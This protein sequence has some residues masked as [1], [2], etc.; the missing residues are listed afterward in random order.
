MA[1]K[2]KTAEQ[3]AIEL[4]HLKMVHAGNLRDKYPHM[5]SLNCEFTFVDFDGQVKPSKKNYS[6]AP[7]N[8]A[9]FE[10]DCPY[11]ECVQGGFDLQGDIH[12]MLLSKQRDI[13][14]ERICQGWQ[15]Q[16]RIGKNRCNCK[17]TYR[18]SAEYA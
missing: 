17:L 3:V 7:E 9:M 16:E 4:K 15:D 18:I 1:R 13:S 5:R 8:S 14:G 10:F 2:K 11:W 12:R 6:L